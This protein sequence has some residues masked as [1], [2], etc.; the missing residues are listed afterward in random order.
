MPGAYL[1]SGDVKRNDAGF[2]RP[3]GTILHC[4]NRPSGSSEKR[5][6]AGMGAVRMAWMGGSSGA[7][8]GLTGGVAVGKKA[9]VFP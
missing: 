2:Q 5:K 1:G 6:Q 9:D 4:V 7:V 8:P 3:W